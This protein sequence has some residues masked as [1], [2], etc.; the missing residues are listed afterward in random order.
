[1]HDEADRE[2]ERELHVRHRGADRLGAV[3]QDLDVDRGRDR[4]LKLRQQ[5]L[6]PIAR[7]R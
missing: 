1:M 4:R 3:G 7:S 6:D 2:D 5:R